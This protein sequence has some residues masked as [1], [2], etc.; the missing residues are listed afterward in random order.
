MAQL[1]DLI[2][3]GASRF[4][5]DIFGNKAQ[6]TTLNAPTSAGGTTYG[7]GSN[8][9]VL[10]SN[11]SSIYWGSDN[12]SDTLVT[13]TISSAET[14][15]YRL[16]FSATADDTTRTET[17]RKDTDLRWQPSTNTLDIAASNANGVIKTS[18]G[19][20]TLNSSGSLTL[21]SASTIYINKPTNSSII[22]TSG[23]A[24][25][26]HVNGYFTT[27]GNFIL[28]SWD[29][30]VNALTHKLYVNGTSAFTNAITLTDNSDAA[31]STINFSRVGY[32]YINIPTSGHFAVSV[33]GSTG[34]N[35]KLDIDGANNTITSYTNDSVTLGTSSVLWKALYLS[36]KSGYANDVTAG[37]N[38]ATGHIGVNT[39]ATNSSNLLLITG[40][41]TI[42]LRP[43][44]TLTDNRYSSNNRFCFED[45]TFYPY[46]T[47]AYSLGTTSKRWSKLYV[48]TADS[49]GTSTTTPIYWN[50]G[51]PAV[52]SNISL[53]ATNTATRAV[54]VGNSVGSVKI[55]AASSNRGLYDTTTSQW[56]IHDN[57]AGDHTY[58]PLWKSKGTTNQPVYFNS[59]GEPAAVSDNSVLTNLGS[60]TAASTYAASPRPGVTGILP[61]ANGGTGQNTAFAALE[62]LGGPSIAAYG[63]KLSTSTD[64]IDSLPSYGTYYTQNS[65]GT[66]AISGTKPV[67]DSGFKAYYIKGYNSNYDIQFALSAGEKFQIRQ[68]TGS[69]TWGSWRQLLD[70]GNYSSYLGNA[71]I[72]YGTCATAAA[73][74]AK[75]VTCSDFVAANLVKGAII[76]VVFDYK[77][78]GAVADITLNV[79]STG[80]KPIKYIRNGALANLPAVGYILANQVYMFHYDGTNW[81]IEN[82]LYDTNTNT[83][84]RTYASATDLDVPLIGSSS[85]NSTTAA[86]TSYTGTY[87]DWYGAIPNDDTKRVKINL[88]TGLL[89]T[90]AGIEST[91]PI[92]VDGKNVDTSSIGD[93]KINVLGNPLTGGGKWIPATSSAALLTSANA[94]DASL[95]D[96]S[97]GN[98][99][100]CEATTL[101]YCLNPS[102][103]LQGYFMT[104]VIIQTKPNIRVVRDGNDKH[105]LFDIKTESV[106]S[107]DLGTSNINWNGSN[108]VKYAGSVSISGTSSTFTITETP[109]SSFTPTTATWGTARSWT[110]TFTDSNGPYEYK[111]LECF[112]D[113]YILFINRQGYLN[114]S[115]R[116]VIIGTSGWTLA[117]DSSGRYGYNGIYTA[118]NPYC[119]V[120]AFYLPAATSSYTPC[121]RACTKAS[122]YTGG[123]GCWFNSSYDDN[124]Q[125]L[126]LYYAIPFNTTHWLIYPYAELSY[127]GYSY[128]Q[129]YNCS[130][131]ALGNQQSLYTYYYIGKSGT[132]YYLSATSGNA[133]VSTF[134]KKLTISS[135]NTFSITNATAPSSLDWVKSLTSYSIHTIWENSNTEYSCAVPL[136]L[137]SFPASRT[138]T[139]SY[140]YLNYMTSPKYDQYRSY[141]RI[142]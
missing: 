102:G 109:L 79:N 22:F 125:D 111:E 97:T 89:K 27:G 104:R 21:N 118:R 129:V 44:E 4:I 57:T 43:N 63:T 85:A 65:S 88:S 75:V 141:I 110:Y 86:W 77:N 20:L 135:S 81:V 136:G 82:M 12:N 64:N 126:C 134:T 24:D 16:L 100:S 117:S 99:V 87:K 35:I 140:T 133:A 138:T 54:E 59:S 137:S 50:D 23:G 26:N 30:T 106:I 66:S 76:G 130:T 9:N 28:N 25:T 11:G 62:A 39:H 55:Y 10:K 7:P 41:G 90:P 70:S 105:Y 74:T 56:I 83:L 95:S 8:G 121:Q 142:K 84:L 119:F 2:V 5:G 51:V 32:N 96:Y 49:Y 73:T 6:L 38:I 69:S 91:G 31:K 52:M 115:A 101:F 112:G 107:G 92:T 128:W 17:S 72:F 113:F 61:I 98:G 34:A 93:I 114:T 29:A 80:A 123:A 103:I 33:N 45:K 71:K 53:V 1:K 131:G 13:Q 108:Y 78:S 68:Q 60:T 67:N 19:S 127:A 122:I 3:N 116:R 124:V 36:G 15:D 42:E 120:G 132:N 14:G 46:T 48:G 139:T 18:F 37:L 94:Y 47:N 58:V 40:A